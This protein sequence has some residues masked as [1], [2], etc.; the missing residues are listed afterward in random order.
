MANFHSNEVVIA[1]SPEDM[2][3][4]LRVMDRNLQANLGE[5]KRRGVEE[6]INSLSAA[7]DV[8]LPCLR[9]YYWYAF[10]PD[11]QGA[12]GALPEWDN[13]DDCLALS[14]AMAAGGAPASSTADVDLKTGGDLALIRFSY[15][16]KWLSNCADLESFLHSLLEGRY[17]VVMLDADEYDGYSSVTM[18][19]WLLEGSEY[20]VELYREVFTRDELWQERIAAKEAGENGLDLVAAARAWAV[21]AWEEYDYLIEAEEEEEERELLR[22]SGEWAYSLNWGDPHEEERLSAI[23]AVCAILKKMPL[24]VGLTGSSYRGRAEH[25]ETLVPGSVVELRSDWESEFFHPVGIEAFDCQGRTLGNVDSNPLGGFFLDSDD[26]LAL[27][28][29]LPHLTAVVDQVEPLSVLSRNA[30]HPRVA[31]RL[32]AEPLDIG[33]VVEE[34]DVLVGL[35]RC[36]RGRVSRTEGGW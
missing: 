34:I 20:P 23:Y 12:G 3:R 14:C 26:L 21:L 2:L 22:E 4:V 25:V 30:R 7:A 31:I 27:A 35:K 15:S 1:A 18:R 19:S 11:P 28:F 5:A 10:A 24:Y 36:D 8:M 29:L 13:Y 33:Q 32:E 16:T 6:G 17:G 9:D